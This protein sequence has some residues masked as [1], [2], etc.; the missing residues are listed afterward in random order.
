MD[1]L[2]T[3]QTSLEGA[4][5]NAR[6]IIQSSGSAEFLVAMS[7]LQT[8]LEDIKSQQPLETREDCQFEAV[9][10]NR[11]LLLDVINNAGELIRPSGCATTTKAA[12]S[13]L[14]IAPVGKDSFFTISAHDYQ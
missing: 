6:S 3:F 5:N 11:E 7:D 13:G 10:F 4:V 2:H 8:L 9:A 12:G 1:R 14:I